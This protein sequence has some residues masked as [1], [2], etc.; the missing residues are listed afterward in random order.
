SYRPTASRCDRNVG[1]SSGASCTTLNDENAPFASTSN[2]GRN[3]LTP[4]A[5]SH[6]FDHDDRSRPLASVS[7]SSRSC[8]VVLEKAWLPK[9]AR[10]AA[11]NASLP[12]QCASCFRTD[13][14]LA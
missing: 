8:N 3:V 4:A 13:A 9:Y 12:T 1:W 6:S 5:C 2:L 10:V 7:A 14:P 11:K